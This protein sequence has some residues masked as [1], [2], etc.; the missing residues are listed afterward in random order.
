[1][2]EFEKLGVIA[3][4]KHFAVNSGDGGRDSYPI[5]YNERLLEEIYFPAFKEGF[6]R[7]GARSVMS[8][9]NSLD[10]SP[11]TANNWL[12]NTKLKKEW[13]FKGFVISD[14]CAVG[15][16]NVLHFTA[17]DYTEATMDAMNGGLDVIFQTDYNHF[18]LFKDGK[19]LTSSEDHR[20][21]GEFWKTLH[22]DCCWGGDFSRPDG[23]HYSMEWQG[24][25]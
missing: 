2:N 8:A 7:A 24:R 22:P 3:T 12:L 16:A 21:L 11:C 15:G 17:R 19:F 25:K 20:T 10:G 5:H 18:N 23:N 14:A 1:M 6:Q 9:Y 13:G 4:P